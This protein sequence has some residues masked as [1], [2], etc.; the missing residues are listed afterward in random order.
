MKC[1]FC[2]KEGNWNMVL[3]NPDSNKKEYKD[4][5]GWI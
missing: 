2:K 3:L 5:R 4:Q 1:D